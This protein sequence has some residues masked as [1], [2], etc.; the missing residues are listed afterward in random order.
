MDIAVRPATDSDTDACGRICY[1]GFRAVNESHNFPPIFP[2]VEAARQ[3]VS[4]FIQHPSVFGLVAEGDH[5]IVGFCFLSERDP[6][7]AIGPI[8]TDPAIQ[9]RG[10][11]RR[12]MEAVL[13]R[14]RG[15]R[16]V[17]LIQ[18]TF[19]VKSLSLYAALGFD[20]RDILVVLSGVPRNAAPS[21]WEIRTL[22][23]SDIAGCEGLHASVHGYTRTN[24]LR[25]ALETGAPIVALRDGRV[26]AYMVAPTNWLANHGVAATEEDMQALLLGA[27][28]LVRG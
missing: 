9:G 23:A 26:R 2:S 12:L 22:S 4:G 19:N 16:G 27:S 6:M 5:R 21:G 14:S 3:R 24:E 18:D 20:A 13:E 15:T 25:D 17:R 11:G 28:Q 7:R 8:V 10:V 1:E